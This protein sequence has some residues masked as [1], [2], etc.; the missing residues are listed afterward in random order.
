M[1]KSPL[2]YSDVTIATSFFD[3]RFDNRVKKTLEA[4]GQNTYK[5]LVYNGPGNSGEYHS[6]S[7][8]QTQLNLACSQSNKM[9]RSAAIL[10]GMLKVFIRNKPIRIIC[11]DI[12]PALPVLV[13]KLFFNRSVD[14]IYDAH[15]IETTLYPSYRPIIRWIENRIIKQ[16]TI[17]ITVNESIAKWM[18]KEFGKPILSLPNYPSFTEIKPLTRDEI[19]RDYDLV[20]SDVLLIYTG[21]LMA[22]E[23]CIREA[24]ASLYYL[25]HGYKLLISA[26]G[27]IDAFKKFAFDVCAEFKIDSKRVIFIGP[28]SESELLQVLGCCDISLLLYNYRLSPNLDINAPN[29][30]FQ[31]MYSGV[32]MVMSDNTSFKDAV[33]KIGPYIGELT[34]PLDIPSIA[35]AIKSVAQ[36]GNRIQEKEAIKSYGQRYQWDFVVQQIVDHYHNLKL[37]S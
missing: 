35:R 23:R 22:G 9:I 31:A 30:F 5:L 2:A 24:I 29:K 1:S 26:V 18:E 13:Y 21:V 12:Q 16:A 6:S 36:R 20:Q 14:V 3:I 28:Y 15:E 17:S 33:E 8:E 34:D 10:F 7:Y 37:K 32:H 25:D 27:D 11:N 19:F 4:F